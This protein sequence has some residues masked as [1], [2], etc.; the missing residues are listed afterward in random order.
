M[1]D[2]WSGGRRSAGDRGTGDRGARAREERV[3]GTVFEP[4][5]RVGVSLGMLVTE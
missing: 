1:R 3:Q 4:G 2:E 5:G